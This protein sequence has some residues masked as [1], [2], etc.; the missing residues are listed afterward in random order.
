MKK[1]V[2]I[3]VV[4]LFVSLIGNVFQFLNNNGLTTELN[5]EKEKTAELETTAENLK[6]EIETI[7]ENETKVQEA[8]EN[9]LK[10]EQERTAELEESIKSLTAEITRL[11]LIY[12]TLKD[13]TP[14]Q[15]A[16]FD[17][18]SKMHVNDVLN[19][20]MTLE[21]CENQQTSIIDIFI[22]ENELPQ[23]G[24][25][26][27]K[28]WKE[29]RNWYNQFESLSDT[30]TPDNTQTP[31]TQN[32]DS[33]Q[34]GGN[35]QGNTQNNNN[36]NSNKTEDTKPVTNNNSSNKPKPSQEQQNKAEEDRQQSSGDSSGSEEWQNMSQEERDA[37][38]DEFYS[39]GGG[40]GT[41]ND[42]NGLVNPDGS[43]PDW[44][45]P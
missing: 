15:L 10:N 40:G 41:F 11:K 29:E 42:D 31:D 28:E 12:S 21:D 8:A 9:E 2:I 17:S 20:E 25:K 39:Q 23:N 14:E 30:Q 33:T 16:Y 26:L 4:V 32:P 45:M 37:I 1:A 24:L 3:L 34:Q 36:N 38:L 43:L 22:M 18:T 5:A 13:L 19:G 44:A 27:F 35:Q 7:R 6:S